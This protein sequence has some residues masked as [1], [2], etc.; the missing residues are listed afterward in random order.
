[1]I[2]RG[3]IPSAKIYEDDQVLSFMDINPINW[4][5]S[6]VIPKRHYAT[7]FEIPAGELQACILVAQ[8]VARAVHLAMGADGLNLVQ[9]NFRAAGQLI[10]HVHFHLIPRSDNDGFLTSWPGKPYP[11]G[12]LPKTLDRIKARMTEPV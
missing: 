11:P 8:R 7:L 6:L 2:V 10:D 4:G 5:H 9:N 12:D 1:M 3:E